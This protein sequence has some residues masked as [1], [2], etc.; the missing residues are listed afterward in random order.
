M[1]LMPSV[2]DILKQTGPL[3]G[4][5]LVAKGGFTDVLD[6]W[7]KCHAAHLIL[8]TV[9]QRYMRL[10]YAV[11]G[12]A[13]LSPSIRR[14]FLTYT[15]I[16]LASQREAIEVRAIRLE[17]DI[18]AISREKLDL[19]RESVCVALAGLPDE[20]LLL[21]HT[22]FMLAGDIAYNMSHRVPRPEKSSGLMVRGSDLD[23]IVV[24]TDDLPTADV[25]A[26]DEAIY[27]QKH[28]LLSHP[29]IQE[30]IDYVLKPLSRVKEQLTFTSFEHMVACKILCECELL[31]GSP[32][33]FNQVMDLVAASGVRDKLNALQ[34]TAKTKRTLAEQILLD[35]GA[36][37][38]ADA[39]LH[40]FYTR[41]EGDEIY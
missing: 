31:Y 18:T 30:E 14:E 9:G 20:P 39:Y 33:L 10:D 28:Y 40:L 25:R 16:G 4:A 5:E 19:A 41:E 36:T 11:E 15:V 12:Y 34:A 26:L 38:D 1:R 24:T 29:G 2:A 21:Q 22:T 13:R 17:M 35:M 27:R 3:T 23:I 6:L 32:F 37:A 7:R 8:R